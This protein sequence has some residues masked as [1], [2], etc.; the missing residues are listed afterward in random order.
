MTLAESNRLTRL[1]TCAFDRS[2]SATGRK[3]GFAAAARRASRSCPAPCIRVRAKTSVIQPAC[4][5]GAGAFGSSS[6][7][8]RSLPHELR[9]TSHP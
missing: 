6:P 1:T 7:E 2:G 8:L 9:T 3:S 4:F 5:R